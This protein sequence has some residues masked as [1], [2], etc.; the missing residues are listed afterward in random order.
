MILLRMQSSTN[1]TSLTAENQEAA[2]MDATQRHS[3]EHMRA[4]GASYSS[5]AA[6]LGLSVN[7][8]KSYC[9]RNNLGKMD[10]LQDSKK[11]CGNCGKPLIQL[12][13]RKPRRFC[14]DPCRRAWWNTHRDQIKQNA[15]Y[16]FTCLHCGADFESYGNS[17]RK[18]CSHTCYIKERFGK[19]Q[20]HDQRAV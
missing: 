16:N 2:E 1:L 10:V 4:G 11:L 18:F 15:I 19:G 17:H 9:K 3:I 12:P 13:K 5:I 6:A 8:V 20:R 7:T 14:S